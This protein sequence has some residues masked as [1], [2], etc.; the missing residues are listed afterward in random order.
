LNY[1]FLTQKERDNETGLDYFGARYYASM[2]GR[3]TGADPYDVNF[4]RQN[5]PDPEE[6]DAVFKDYLF[7]PQHWN[8]YAYAVNNPLKYVDPDG[9]REYEPVEL[10]G[11]KVKIKISDNLRSEDGKKLKGDDLKK[12]QDKIKQNI[13]NAI[14]KINSGQAQLSTEQITAINSMKGIEVRTDIPY[15]G[16]NGSTFQMTQRFSETDDPETLPAAFIHDS[17]HADQNRRGVPSMGIEAE[18][19]ASA[20]TVPIL[21]KLGMSNRII[22]SY[23]KDAREGH[24]SWGQK[25]RPP[26]QK[27]P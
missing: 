12:A 3:F 27:T 5:T 7:Q 8:R 9:L 2:Q 13:D 21:E 26:K 10:L 4:E 23:R 11:K 14:A 18:K 24:G 22:E 25:S 17:F 20:F 19:Q 15:P 16:M 6:A 1:P